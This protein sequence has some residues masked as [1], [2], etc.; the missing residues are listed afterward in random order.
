M[1]ERQAER[2]TAEEPPCYS[3]RSEIDFALDNRLGGSDDLC[4]MLRDKRVLQNT[5]QQIE[6][7]FYAPRTSVDH[8]ESATENQLT[9]FSEPSTDR[10]GGLCTKSRTESSIRTVRRSM[11][12][13]DVEN[14]ELISALSAVIDR[15]YSAESTFCAK[16]RGGDATMRSQVRHSYAKASIASRLAAFTAG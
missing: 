6:R 2:C 4:K 9:C 8:I 16:P 1:F 7:F 11:T 10:R 5:L 15:R 12:D 14:K 3:H 13:D